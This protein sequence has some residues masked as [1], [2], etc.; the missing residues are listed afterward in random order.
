ML[1]QL[2]SL[3][4]QEFHEQ[5]RQMQSSKDDVEYR[6][7]EVTRECRQ[8]RDERAHIT[9]ESDRHSQQVI[10]LERRLVTLQHDAALLKDE[11][12]RSRKELALKDASNK[13]V[14]GIR[15]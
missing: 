12:E 1:R 5:L 6:L 7:E 15:K 2:E 8:A 9:I 10:E 13:T 14:F 11:K 3:V 4:E